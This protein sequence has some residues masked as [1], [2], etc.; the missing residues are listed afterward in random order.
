MQELTREE[1]QSLSSFGYML[2]RMGKNDEAEK[3]Y[4][5]L[6]SLTSNAKDKHWLCKNL[7]FIYL[8]K[9][10]YALALDFLRRAIGDGAVKSEN[11]FLYLLRAEALWHMSRFAEAENSLK[12][13]YNLVS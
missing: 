12:Q 7:A 3:T 5:A 13:Y 11:A 1:F 8:R 6:L 2:L 9:K 4:K 10:E